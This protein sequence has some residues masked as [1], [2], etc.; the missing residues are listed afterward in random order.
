M[1]P[2][3]LYNNENNPI[4][5]AG[6]PLHREAVTKIELLEIIEDQYGRRLTMIVINSL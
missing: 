6:N 4:C 3:N 5:F 2:T 1:K